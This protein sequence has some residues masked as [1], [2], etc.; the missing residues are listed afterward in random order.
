MSY[1]QMWSPVEMLHLLSQTGHVKSR[2][3][4]EMLVE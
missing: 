3:R 4:I 1:F 2:H